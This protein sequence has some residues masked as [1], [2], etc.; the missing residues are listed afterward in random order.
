MNNSKILFLAGYLSRRLIVL[1]RQ[2]TRGGTPVFI[3]APKNK[4]L[5]YLP[6]NQYV[7]IRRIGRRLLGARKI[8]EFGGPVVYFDL[9]SERMVFRENITAAGFKGLIGI[10]LNVWHPMAV[11]GN[12]QTTLLT[13]YNIAPHHKMLLATDP[14]ERSARD[15][16][17]AIKGLDRNDYIIALYGK[18]GKR[19]ARRLAQ[20]GKVIFLGAEQDL[21]SLIRSAFA[22]ISLSAEP[23]FYKIAAVA[24]GRVT[25]WQKS[26]INPNVLIK[27]DLTDAIEQIL[28]MPLKQR[29]A[30]E[31]ENLALAKS[32]DIEKNIAKIIGMTK[33]FYA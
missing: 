5:K 11:S 22:V 9:E 14:G 16:V 30:F 12:R 21:P 4:N 10:D 29:A 1:A 28:D 7:R 20:T 17:L 24:M 6:E 27:D 3:A 18:I 33:Q 32:F 25:A 2:M 8:R 19:V 13:Q 15:L 26:N 31:K 23:S